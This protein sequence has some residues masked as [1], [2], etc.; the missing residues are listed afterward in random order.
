MQRK[1]NASLQFIELSPARKTPLGGNVVTSL[2]AN[3]TTFPALPVTIAQLTAAN[4]ALANAIV[5]AASGD[6][7][8]KANL[9]NAEKAWD[10]AFRKTANYVST[11]ANGD[12]AIIAKGGFTPTKNET[13]PVQL[14]EVSKNV[15][16]MPERGRGTISV[17]CDA[18]INAKAYVYVAAPDGVTVTQ[19]GN[20]LVIQTGD[21]KLYVEA[22]THRKIMMHNL[23]GGVP[24][25][26]SMMALNN[27][28]CGPLSS[29]QTI[30]PQ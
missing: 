4:T 5:T 18:D 25:N 14:P 22:D 21:T 23:G 19:D 16:A 8:A 27:A 1:S 3:A 7:V 20:M 6:H 24:L 9:F 30:I 11:V 29:A 17:G 13:Q 28:G 10:T 26:V 2:T 12:E 15:A